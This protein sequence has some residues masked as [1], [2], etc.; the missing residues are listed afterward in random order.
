MPGVGIFA[1][2]FNHNNT[3]KAFRQAV[4]YSI[5]RPEIIET[6]LGG[7]ATLNYTIP[8]GFKVYDDINK[9]EFD[10]DRASELLATSSWGIKTRSASPSWPRTRTSPS[11]PRRSSSTLQAIGIK[12]EL[13]ALPTRAVH[14]P[15]PED[16]RLRGIYLSLRRQ[17]GRGLV[18]V[19]DLLRL[20]RPR[21]DLQLKMSGD[22]ASA[23]TPT[24]SRRRLP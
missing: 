8:P 16:R 11:R 23:S 9:Y 3:D 19:L 17:R 4:A 24:S 15:D 6:V 21:H 20:R 22:A 13:T 5:N 10:P 14:R 12:V 18:P 1:I 2:N 7:L